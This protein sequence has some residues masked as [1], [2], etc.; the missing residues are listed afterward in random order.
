MIIYSHK[1]SQLVNLL[2]IDTSVW[3]EMKHLSINNLQ[4]FQLAH[5]IEK[6]I[7][8]LWHVT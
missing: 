3:S 8:D 2:L 5:L 6:G 1:F 4:N 7:V